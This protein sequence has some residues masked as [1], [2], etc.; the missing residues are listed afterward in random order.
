MEN[1]VIKVYKFKRR[2]ICYI[3]HYNGVFSTCTGKPSDAGCISW[4][5]NNMEEAEYTAKEYFHNRTHLNILN[6]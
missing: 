4:T 3:R 1:G 2:I 6:Q 5:Y